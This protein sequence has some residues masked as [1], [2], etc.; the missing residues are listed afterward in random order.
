V[1]FKD[2]VKQKQ[3]QREWQRQKRAAEVKPSQGRTLNPEDVKTAQG[4]R[5]LLSEVLADVQQWDGDTLQR[6]RCIGYI[7]AIAL[8]AVETADL[9][10]RLTSLEE[11][12]KKSRKS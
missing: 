1:P 10:Y 5:N 12:L 2:D 3:Y 9:E 6:A 7:A 4:I 11:V 8:K